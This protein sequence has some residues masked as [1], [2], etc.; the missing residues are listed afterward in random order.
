[1]SRIA[2]LFIHGIIGTPRHFT[3]LI[4]LVQQVPEDFTVSNIILD[5]HGGTVDDFAHTSMAK[6]KAQVAKEI[7]RLSESH[8]KLI[9]VAHSMGSLL[10]IQQAVT[11]P[12]RISELFLLAV[13][14]KIF[15][16]PAAFSNSIKVLT[17]KISPSDNMGQAA[18]KSF[19][20]KPDKR[21][22]KYLKWIPRYL[23]LFTEIRKT[24]KILPEI[25][26]PCQAYQSEKDEMVWP[27]TYT[28]LKKN[29]SL[30]VKL[31]KTSTHYL[32]GNQDRDLVLEQFRQLMLYY[33]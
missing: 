4:P 27:G 18:L 9:V 11:C 14:L 6:W 13:P 15:L 22:W 24:R 12:E 20:M 23:E 5:G 10:A 3:E 25:S 19:G 26:I 21:I 7:Q 30:K 17:G 2:V 16:K 8:T 29:P 33:N 1:V 28:L 32:Y 31:L